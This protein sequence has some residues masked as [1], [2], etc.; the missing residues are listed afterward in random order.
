VR[1]FHHRKGKEEQ[2][3]RKKRKSIRR[4]RTPVL[5]L[6]YLEVLTFSVCSSDPSWSSTW[7]GREKSQIRE[8]L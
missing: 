4:Y 2:G 6:P 5:R 8:K 7:A 1:V 3:A